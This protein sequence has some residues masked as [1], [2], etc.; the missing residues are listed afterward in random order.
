MINSKFL[1]QGS[2]ALIDGTRTSALL[3]GSGGPPVCSPSFGYGVEPTPQD[4][5]AVRPYPTIPIPPAAE[6]IMPP[7]IRVN[8]EQLR[9]KTI[10]VLEEYFSI[11]M[12]IRMLDEALLCVEELNSP[13]YHHELVKESTSLALEKSP[14]CIELLA[15]L[16]D[17]LVAKKVLTPRDI[18]TG[19]LLYGLM[20]EEIAIDLP[21]APNTFGEI[22]GRLV[23]VGGLDF[24]VVKEVLNKVEDPMFQRA[25]FTAAMSTITSSPSGQKV[26]DSQASDIKACENLS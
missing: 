23:L 19:C 16:L 5:A 1:P 6:K 21:R 20:L 15:K 11:R 13:D 24:K 3:Q 8:T 18:G 26:L 17:H 25:L 22:I 9:K 7:P 10:S 12:C 2:G 14:P 4:P